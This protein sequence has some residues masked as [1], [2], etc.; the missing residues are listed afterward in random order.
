VTAPIPQQ[1]SRSAAPLYGLVAAYLVSDTGTAMSAVAVPWL[2]LVITGSAAD[3]GIVGFAQMA[4]YVS[5]QAIA[6]PIVDRIGLRRTFLLGNTVAAIAMS[7]IPVLHAAG[8]L[9]LGALAGLVAVAGAVRG[10]AD[11][12]SAPLVP[13]LA[14]LGNVPYERATGIYSGAGRAALLLGMPAAGALIAAA[15]P[16]A[17][18]LIDGISF[19]VGV[20]ILAAF[21]PSSIGRA[22]PASSAMTLRS[23]ASD[24]TEG[25]RFLRADRLLLGLAV[26]SCLTNLLDQ[27]FTSVLLPVWAHDR[28]HR[29]IAIGL[30]GGVLGVG[31]LGGVLLG[32]WLG[33]RLPRRIIYSV[34]M[35]VSASP[36]FFA[37]AAWA[38]LSPVL[39][40]VLFCGVAGG[41][42]NPI[43][44]AVMYERIPSRLQARVL[45]AVK[46]CAWL[47]IPFG[48]L[49]GGL[50]TQ[51]AG[52]TVT[53]VLAGS[54]M[55]LVTLGP[56][57]FPAWRG[58]DRQPAAAAAGVAAAEG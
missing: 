2:V 1:R 4:P 8:K 54:L 44:G 25:L 9:D 41:V 38:S 48:S 20:V 39:P 56:L 23:Y 35:L 28:V 11:C 7:A 49:L 32:A 17:V 36:P 51:A 50:V 40:I 15:G 22:E 30:V 58:L 55:F 18:V 26:I 47:G 13:S 45:G 53:L 3:T 16:S 24:L 31:L 46:A 29:A 21:V 52:L 33:P 14:K 43:S 12:A 37:L 27:A 19:A 10:L 5:L 42:M 34:G 6:G 57:V